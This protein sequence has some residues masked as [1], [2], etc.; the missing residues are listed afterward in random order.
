MDFLGRL[1]RRRS[2]EMDTEVA[3]RLQALRNPLMR[4][5]A[6]SVRDPSEV[7]DLV[8]EVFARVL[9]RGTLESYDRFSG[10]V[11]QAANNVLKDRHRR[12]SAR[13]QDLHVEFEP[14]IHASRVPSPEDELLAREALAA[15]SV[16]LSQL[17]EMVQAVFVLRRL[18]GMSFAE[19][20][21]R[22]GISLSTAEKH[23]V[24]A[25]RHLIACSRAEE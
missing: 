16:A 14:D 12:R 3:E 7:E 24:R 21:A 2:Q 4:Y 13:R 18:E 15:T 1:G 6:R 23:M 9:R 25:A 22:L 10:Y 8:Q 17:P 11:F 20:T 5:F 19:I